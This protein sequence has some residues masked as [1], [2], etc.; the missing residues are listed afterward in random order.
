MKKP[1]D[2]ESAEPAGQDE[3]GESTEQE[4]GD[5][6]ASMLGVS[7]DDRADFLTAL[8]GYVRACAGKK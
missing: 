6:L 8:S 7:E 1:A 2:D 5:E 3:S 4:Y